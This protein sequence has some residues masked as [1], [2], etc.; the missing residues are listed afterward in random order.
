MANPQ[1]QLKQIEA[2]LRIT[3]AIN[4]LNGLEKQKV[5][6]DLKLEYF[7]KLVDI[8]NEDIMSEQLKENDSTMQLYCQEE[9]TKLTGVVKNLS[10]RIETHKKLAEKLK[11]QHKI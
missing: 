6:A 10:E 4:Q 3:N 9:L 11:E 8:V 1:D 2:S 5:A 7:S